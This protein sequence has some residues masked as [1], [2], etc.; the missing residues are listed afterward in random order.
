MEEMQRVSSK[1]ILATLDY[2]THSF[3]LDNVQ[4]D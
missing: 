3:I 1:E 4:E 2:K